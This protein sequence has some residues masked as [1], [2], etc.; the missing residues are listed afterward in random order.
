V[1]TDAGGNEVE[2]VSYLPF[3]EISQANSSGSDVVT[4]KFS[5]Q[6]YDPEAD[7]A[8][9]GARYYDPH[10]G[11]FI[12]AD[13]AVPNPL[14]LQSLNRYSYVRNNPINRIDPSGHIDEAT[15]GSIGTVATLSWC[16]G[17]EVGLP[18][19]GAAVV[20]VAGIEIYD[21]AQSVDWD[22]TGQKFDQWWHKSTDKFGN[23]VNKEVDKAFNP[24][25]QFGDWV[26]GLFGRGHHHHSEGSAPA[27]GGG[28][29]PSM[30]LP[31]PPPNG[32]V[33][34]TSAPPGGGGS[35]PSNAPTSNSVWPVKGEKRITNLFHGPNDPMCGVSGPGQAHQNGHWGMDLAAPLSTEIVAV[36][37]GSIVNVG[38][39]SDGINHV[40]MMFPDGVHVKFLHI[41]PYVK[42]GDSVSA[43][44]TIGWSDGSGGVAPHLHL[45]YYPAGAGWG[46]SNPNERKDPWE[47]LLRDA[48]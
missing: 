42:T 25:K 24:V 6:E 36:K 15:G 46:V 31:A 9:Y 12:S 33:G 22:R 40:D 18:V 13:A 14:D 44:S 19:T 26:G 7:L 47:P 38:T 45:D 10:L 32:A 48:W 23:W 28:G 5:G 39:Y 27:A 41:F 35:S 43:G 30:A 3:G 8:Y 4:R 2:R 29:G 21:W 34:Q 11:R 37:S 17:P 16:L 20:V 1:I